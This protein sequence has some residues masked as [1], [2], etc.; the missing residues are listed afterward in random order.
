ML[1][2]DRPAPVP[3]GFAVLELVDREAPVAF[4]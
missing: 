1:A 4:V 3:E 2:Y